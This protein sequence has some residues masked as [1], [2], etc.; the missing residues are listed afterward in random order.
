MQIAAARGRY[1]RPFAKILL[2][3]VALREKQPELARTQLIELVAEFPQNPLF[4][5]E[6]AKLGSENAVE[7]KDER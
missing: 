1:L 5:K 4:A 7:D 2:A 3:L 6:L